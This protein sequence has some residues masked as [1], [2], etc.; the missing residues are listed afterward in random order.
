MDAIE[1][2]ILPHRLFDLEEKAAKIK[3]AE[4]NHNSSLATDTT[5][6]RLE[7]LRTGL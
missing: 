3:N 1:E 6:G 4:K 5:K 7:I 2:R